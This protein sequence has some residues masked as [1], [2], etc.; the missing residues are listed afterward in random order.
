MTAEAGNGASTWERQPDESEPAYAAFEHFLRSGAARTIR[1]TARALGKA[2]SL[3]TR[4]ARQHGWRARARAYDL[5]HARQDEVVIRE[6]RES[7]L[8]RTTGYLERILQIVIAR[9]LQLAHRDPGTG[10]VSFDPDLTPQ[11]A[12]ALLKLIVGLLHQHGQQP[13]HDDGGEDPAGQLR[14]LPSSE[15]EQLIRFIRDAAQEDGNV[16]T[17]TTEESQE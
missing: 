5:E 11:V 16:E 13:S 9:L 1:G 4:W 2:R 3:L 10:Q 15:L 8:R 14:A 6:E 17:E 7:S 12:A